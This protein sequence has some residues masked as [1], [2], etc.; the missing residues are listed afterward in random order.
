MATKMIIST[1]HGDQYLIHEDGQIE[2]S[3]GRNLPLS[4]QWKLLGIEHVKRRE[5]IPFADLLA[6][7]RPDAILYKNGNPQ[8]T[9]RDNDHGAVRTWGN[10]KYHGIRTISA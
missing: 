4:G 9:V 5:F 3:D 8:W 1:P 7:K 10:T 6:G 2:R